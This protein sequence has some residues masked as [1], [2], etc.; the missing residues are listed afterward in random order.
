MKD[1]SC[2]E[3]R[4]LKDAT[5]H[6]ME[7]L[8]DDGVNRHLRFKNPECTAYWFDIITW[9]GTLCVDGDMGTFV[10]RRLHD[11]FEFFRTD[12]KYYE[13]TGRADRLAINPSYW[14]EKLRA[15]KP[16]D[17]MEYS[18]DRFRRHVKEAFDN[19]VDSSQPDEDDSTEAERD[20]FM[21]N[22][23][24]LWEALED[25][26]L[27]AADDGE[28]VRAYDAARDF[29]CA[30]VPGFNMEDCWEWDCREFTFDFIWN[31][32]A[33]AWGIKQYDSS[34][35]QAQAVETV[36]GTQ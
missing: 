24:A 5:K 18:A 6:Q 14:D 4:F 23:D 30:E 34:K 13:D 33:I 1:Y 31:C 17:A 32:Y 35:A 3:A 9:P 22:K 10:F 29:S 8:R 26:V 15:P 2:T 11:M 20:E 16:R 27:S 21:G 12:R 28:E 36:G 7:V 19:W 25:D